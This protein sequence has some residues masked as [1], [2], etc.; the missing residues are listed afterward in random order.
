MKIWWINSWLFSVH[1]SA[2]DTLLSFFGF[3]FFFFTSPFFSVMPSMCPN[4]AQPHVCDF[5]AVALGQLQ[6]LCM[7]CETQADVNRRRTNAEYILLVLR[8]LAE[9]FRKKKKK[10]LTWLVNLAECGIYLCRGLVANQAPLRYS[11]KKKKSHS[12]SIVAMKIY[13]ASGCCRLLLA[14]VTLG[15]LRLAFEV[16]PQ[17]ATDGQ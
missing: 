4:S 10:D 17:S 8:W 9:Q 12:T 15:V 14:C 6:V 1:R 16:T 5:C 11:K 2:S 7:T 13:S 3:F